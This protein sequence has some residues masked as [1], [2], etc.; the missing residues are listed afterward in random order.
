M[1]LLMVAAGSV[2]NGR[3]RLTAGKHTRFLPC[4][5]GSGGA[6]TGFQRRVRMHIAG[7]SRS[8]RAVVANGTC[9][10]HHTSGS[11]TVP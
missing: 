3:M 10:G 6:P 11:L 8:P 2:V 7:I 4:P 1:R 9:P 5:E